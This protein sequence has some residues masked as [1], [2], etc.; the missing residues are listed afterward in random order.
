MSLTTCECII[1]G[2]ISADVIKVK[3]VDLEIGGSSLD[4]LGQLSVITG[5]PTS[6]GSSPAGG[7]GKRK[8]KLGRLQRERFWTCRRWFEGGQREPLGKRRRRNE[9]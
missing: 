4:Y 8:G 6:K 9:I 7:R 2:K 5:A 1:C 3:S